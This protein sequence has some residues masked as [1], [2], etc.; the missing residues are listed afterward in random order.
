MTAPVLPT[1]T[2]QRDPTVPPSPPKAAKPRAVSEFYGR[3]LMDQLNAID[4]RGGSTADKQQF[5]DMELRRPMSAAPVTPE[6][7]GVEVPQWY[8]GASM[9]VLQGATFGFGDEAMG[10]LLGTLTGVGARAGIDEYRAE[11]EAWANANRKSA[12]AGEI[13][14]SLLTA[15]APLGIGKLITGAGPGTWYGAVGRGTAIGALAGAGAGTGDFSEAG[16]GE[17]T[18]AALFG[19]A[20][21]AAVS[22]GLAGLS[23]VARPILAPMAQRSAT[24]LEGAAARLEGAAPNIAAILRAPL[25]GHTPEAQAREI[26]N[27]VL[28]DSKIS[29]GEA[30]NRTAALLSTG[31]PATLLEVGGDPMLT[32][33]RNVFSN[34]SPAV[35]GALE[36]L[37]TRQEAQS[38]RLVGGFLNSALN[39]RKLGIQNIWNAADELHATGLRDSAPFYADAF[40]QTVRVSDRMYKL[41]RHPAMRRAWNIGAKLAHDETL[42]GIG[43]GLPVKAMPPIGMM[44]DLPVRGID[45]LKRGLDQLVRTRTKSGHMSLGDRQAQAWTRMK[46]ELVAE[47]IDQVPSYG[48]ALAAYSGPIGARDALEEG[49]N[50][51]RKSWQEVHKEVLALSPNDRDFYRAGAARAFYDEMLKSRHGTADL[52]AKFFGGSVVGRPSAEALRIRAMFLN[53]NAAADNFQRLVAGEAAISHSGGRVLRLPSSTSVEKFKEAAEGSVLPVRGNIGLTIATAART[54]VERSRVR[55]SQE[56]NDALAEIFVRGLTDPT[57]LSVLLD[58]LAY[59]PVRGGVKRALGAATASFAGSGAGALTR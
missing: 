42:A 8:R 29:I 6:S 4:L 30:R 2:T 49:S 44:P 24:A 26:V 55:L 17:R 53:N 5:L 1:P 9:S 7:L 51:L 20:T 36:Q 59:A 27:R 43:H 47:T 34:A 50:I 3:Y 37:A 45:Y 12:I 21:G 35:T 14:G 19:A 39:G 58:D 25:S 10:A 18:R 52:A 56:V 54:A 48:K 22:G 57:H 38:A 46:D 40:E 16:L 32:L 31:T 23:A 11:Y 41:L 33:A 13:V 28:A 15:K